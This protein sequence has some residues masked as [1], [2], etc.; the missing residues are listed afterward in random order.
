M[1]IKICTCTVHNLDL[2]SNF[3]TNML[4]GGLIGW[5]V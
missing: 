4:T 2:T 3:V 5:G 1:H